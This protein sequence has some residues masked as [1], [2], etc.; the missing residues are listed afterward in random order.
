M[1][2]I[3]NSSLKMTRIELSLASFKKACLD[4]MIKIELKEI[5]R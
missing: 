3:C 2:R 4:W 5:E 1:K